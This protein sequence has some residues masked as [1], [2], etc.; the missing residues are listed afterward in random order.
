MVA[1]RYSVPAHRPHSGCSARSLVQS[2]ANP[3]GT[4]VVVP[5]RRGLGAWQMVI[6]GPA[7]R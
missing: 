1:A 6:K 2:A 7:A 3:G 4:A 5:S